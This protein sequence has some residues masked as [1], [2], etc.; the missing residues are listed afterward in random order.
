[1]NDKFLAGGNLVNLMTRLW[2]CCATFRVIHS[3]M[4]C[5]ANADSIDAL[6]GACD[7]LRGIVDD[8]QA[9]IDSSKDYEETT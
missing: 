6:Y 4:E 7:L 1:M 9:D 3:S 2:A 5:E 8:L